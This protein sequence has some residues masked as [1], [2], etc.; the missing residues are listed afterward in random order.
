MVI[1]LGKPSD[2]VDRLE[3][4]PG[5][6]LAQRGAGRGASCRKKHRKMGRSCCRSRAPSFADR[7][8]AAPGSLLLR[9]ALCCSPKRAAAQ[10]ALGAQT[11][12]AD[13]SRSGCAARQLAGD[14]K[15]DGVLG[16]RG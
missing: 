2:K 10:L 7:V 4:R 15:S 8:A 16:R 11:V 6:G 5:L 14:C 3:R 12:L 9:G 13:F 1:T